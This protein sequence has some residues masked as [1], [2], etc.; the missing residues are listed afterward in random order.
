MPAIFPPEVSVT[1]Q[2]S[3]CHVI[4]DKPLNSSQHGD[5]LRFVHLPGEMLSAEANFAVR[6]PILTSGSRD[7]IGRRKSLVTAP[8]RCGVGDSQEVAKKTCC[9]LRR[10]SITGLCFTLKVK[11]KCFF[12]FRLRSL[13]QHLS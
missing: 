11:N 4:V 7:S 13:L 6:L 10:F 1:F 9:P 2:L 8:W 12:F 3:F 5:T